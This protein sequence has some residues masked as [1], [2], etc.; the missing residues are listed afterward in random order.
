MGISY[1]LQIM[2][3]GPGEGNSDTVDLSDFDPAVVEVILLHAYGAKYTLTVAKKC[4]RPSSRN[5]VEVLTD[6]MGTE[7]IMK[8]TVQEYY[9]PTGEMQRWRKT[10]NY[11]K[12]GIAIHKERHG[13]DRL[14]STHFCKELYMHAGVHIAAQGLGWKVSPDHRFLLQY[15]CQLLTLS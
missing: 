4:K 2:A 6:G 8:M 13:V 15:E 12:A 5:I 14:V 11:H 1:F 9:T 3:R 7:G 10:R